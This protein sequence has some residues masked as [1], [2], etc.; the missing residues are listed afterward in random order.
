[1][2]YSDPTVI[3]NN[4]LRRAFNDEIAISP[5]KLQKIMYFVASE[6][7]KVTGEQLFEERFEA[8][9]YGPVLR[10]VY[11]EF[12]PFG[13][14]PITKYATQD[15]LGNSFGVNESTNPELR[16]AL[17]K[18]WAATR[19]LGAIKLYE[20]THAENS[21]WDRARKNEQRFIAPNDVTIDDTYQ[22]ELML[23][24]YT[25]SPESLSRVN[26]DVGE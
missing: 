25:A 1:M 17:D 21:A 8:W 22:N 3:S 13:G 7:A 18:V 15:A 24:P 23:P 16:V 6:Y 4:I 19:D 11:R 14:Y 12:K 26:G 2:S 10:S 20:L 5:L 9:R